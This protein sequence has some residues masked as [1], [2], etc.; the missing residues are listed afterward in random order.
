MNGLQLKHRGQERV[1]GNNVTFVRE[2][3][4]LAKTIAE[5]EGRVTTDD[6]RKIA[7]KLDIHPEHPNAWGCVIG[8]RHGFKA[9]GWAT[10]EFASRHGAPIRIWEL[11]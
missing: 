3:R 6:L 9:V 2:M 4:H 10:S 7:D 5:C 11:A 8:K 1:E